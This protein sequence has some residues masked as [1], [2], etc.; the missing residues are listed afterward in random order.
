MSLLCP[1]R[2]EVLPVPPLSGLVVLARPEPWEGLEGLE[3]QEQ[4]ERPIAFQG[5]VGTNRRMR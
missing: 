2:G 4:Q 3:S 1:V 5:E